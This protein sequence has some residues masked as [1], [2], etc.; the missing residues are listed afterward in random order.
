MCAVF[1][2]FFYSDCTSL[3][4]TVSLV[5]FI[6]FIH[7]FIHVNIDIYRQSISGK[8][9][10]HFIIDCLWD[11][12]TIWNVDMPSTHLLLFCC[13]HVCLTAVNSRYAICDIQ[14]CE[15]VSFGWIAQIFT[16][17]PG[18]ICVF[19]KRIGSSRHCCHCR[20]II[21]I[22]ATSYMWYFHVCISL[23]PRYA[24]LLLLVLLVQLILGKCYYIRCR[25]LVCILICWFNGFTFTCMHRSIR[26]H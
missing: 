19:V 20:W 10:I 25:S 14:A 24:L 5:I 4:F 8:T 12:I 2:F 11:T 22:N 3:L 21:I 1:F 18:S 26:S 17:Y 16:Y 9:I 13:V 15:R 7:S 6:I 23:A